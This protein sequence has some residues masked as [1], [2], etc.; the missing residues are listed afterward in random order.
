MCSMINI[1]DI[2]FEFKE[3]SVIED[4]IKYENYNYL[5]YNGKIEDINVTILENEYISYEENVNTLKNILENLDEYKQLCCSNVKAW[6]GYDGK[7]ILKEIH[8]GYILC[9]REIKFG[10]FFSLTFIKDSQDEWSYT[11]KFSNRD[12]KLGELMG[13]EIWSEKRIKQSIQNN[14][15]M[16]KEN[17]LKESEKYIKTAMKRK[18]TEYELRKLFFKSIVRLKGEY[19][20]VYTDDYDVNKEDLLIN[21]YYGT[22]VL[23]YY[24]YELPCINNTGDIIKDIY[25]SN[26][27]LKFTIEDYFYPLGIEFF[28]I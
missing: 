7:Y 2:K 18:E 15:L 27:N 5:E 24:F 21:R 6:F 25:Y 16:P 22:K 19:E 13:G 4:N 12:K 10:S 3:K 11:I 20:E 17:Y 23:D 26:Y 9:D 8:C 28:V 14:N 1:N